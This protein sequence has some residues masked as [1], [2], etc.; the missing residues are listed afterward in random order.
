MSQ[1]KESE[2]DRQA[3]DQIFK[4][5]ILLALP[6]LAFQRD[7]LAIG[8]RGIQDYSHVRPL[9]NFALREMQALRMALDP[10][11]KWTES[12]AGLDSKLEETAAQG[13]SKFMSA[14]GG[15]LEAQETA[16]NSAID[17]LNAARTGKK[18]P[19]E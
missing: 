6:W 11:R 2:P 18:K 3:G 8:K 19:A 5:C 4:S 10:S 1:D 15:I 14:L 17:A 12:T 16:L 9:Q 7:M 13:V